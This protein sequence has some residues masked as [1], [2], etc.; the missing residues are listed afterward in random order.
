MA[1]SN[2]VEK[3]EKPLKSVLLK[4]YIGQRDKKN[5]ILKLGS[6]KVQPTY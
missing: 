4:S 1:K 3:N 6:Q 2:K 5:N